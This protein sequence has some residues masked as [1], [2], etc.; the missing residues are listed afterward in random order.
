MIVLLLVAHPYIFGAKGRIAEHLFA[1]H[2]H[3]GMTPEEVGRTAR[4]YGGTD[5]LGRAPE[6]PYAYTWVT[7]G[8]QDVQFTDVMTLCVSGGT[9][10]QLFYSRDLKLTEWHAQPWGS[11]C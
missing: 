10:Y 6:G 11:A 3:T 7:D 2:I 1:R 8:R 5:L 4:T 9:D